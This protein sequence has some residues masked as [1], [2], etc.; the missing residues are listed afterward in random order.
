MENQIICGDNVAVLSTLPDNCVDLTVTS[1]PYDT[2]RVADGYQN[3]FDLLHLVEQLHRVTKPG[4]MVVWVVSDQTVDG[5]K[6]GTSFRHAFQFMH[7][8]FLLFDDIV[9]LKSGSN[10][11]SKSRYTNTWEHMF[12]FSKGQPKTVNLIKDQ[13]RLWKGSWGKTKNRKKDG[14]LQE[15]T[16]TN[17]GD[18]KLG[19]AVGDEYGYKARTNVWSITNGKGFAHPDPG[20]ELAYQH[21]ASFPLQLAH[22]HI[23]SWTNEGDLVLDPFNGAGTT[24]VAA[25]ATKRRY[26][27]VDVSPQYCNLAEQR[28][29]AFYEATND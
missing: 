1:P 13:R 22:D 21:P 12:C 29:R 11:P 27:G 20:G 7:Q 5:G 23:V 16:A 17:C 6:T 28:V 24:C 4:G 14:T 8:G 10:F 26:V 15:S 25:A 3:Q 18:G 9:Y 2:I 19:K